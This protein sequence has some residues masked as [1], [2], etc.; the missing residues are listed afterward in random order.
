MVEIVSPETV[1]RISYPG[2]QVPH[3]GCSRVVDRSLVGYLLD[4]GDNP[5]YGNEVARVG[6]HQSINQGT[7]TLDVERVGGQEG[8][9]DHTTTV[10]SRHVH[11][12]SR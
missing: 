10:L 1:P 9:L 11:S 4:D 5:W 3:F 8:S 12:V 7:V 6:L 2:G